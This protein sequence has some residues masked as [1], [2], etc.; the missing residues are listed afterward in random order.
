VETDRESGRG[1]VATDESVVVMV[2]GTGPGKVVEKT[3]SLLDGV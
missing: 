2:K 3:F 1:A